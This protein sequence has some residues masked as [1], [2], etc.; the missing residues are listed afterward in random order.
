MGEEKLSCP[1]YPYKNIRGD[2]TNDICEEKMLQA[3]HTNLEHSLAGNMTA[4]QRKEVTGVMSQ[5]KYLAQRS[6][7]APLVIGWSLPTHF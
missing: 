5:H 6:S 2:R 4:T 3:L 7:Q 1:R